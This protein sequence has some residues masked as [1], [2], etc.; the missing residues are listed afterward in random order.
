MLC[1]S[2]NFSKV[3]YYIKCNSLESR[4]SKLVKE[5]YPEYTGLIQDYLKELLT[6]GTQKD[7]EK[8]TDSELANDF[9][10]YGEYILHI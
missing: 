9:A 10:A 6:S 5:Y 3:D 2:E 1:K 7:L 4:L 8:Y